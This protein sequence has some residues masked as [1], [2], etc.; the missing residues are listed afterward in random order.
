MTNLCNEVM[1]SCAC[2]GVRR[3]ARALTQYYDRALS[4]IGLKATQFPILVALEVAGPV[5]LSPLADALVMDR[6]TLTRNLKALEERD[7]VR[8]EEGQD[9]RVR[10]LSLTSEG[11]S[12]LADALAIWQVTQASVKDNF[13]ADRLDD[14]MGELHHLTGSVRA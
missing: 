3:S 1:R 2:Q 13:G 8:V 9:R 6:T 4:P 10:L 5:P 7:L 11:R 14:L 12:L